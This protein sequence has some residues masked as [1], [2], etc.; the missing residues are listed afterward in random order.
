MGAVSNAAVSVN[1]DACCQQ[2]L[3]AFDALVGEI[4]VRRH[5]ERL[6]ERAGKMPN[7]FQPRLASAQ[8]ALPPG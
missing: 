1:R 2:A 8:S 6:L 3:G 5:V 7:Y 4:A